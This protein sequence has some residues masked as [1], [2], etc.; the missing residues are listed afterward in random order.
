MHTFNHYVD[1]HITQFLDELKSFCAQPSIAATGEGIPEMADLVR[2]TLAD[3]G[4]EVQL[5]RLTPDS[6]PIVYGT[7][8]QGDKTLL[9]YNH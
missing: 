1:Q 7:L 4:A 3:L 6:P 8:G 2:E 5:L 9:I